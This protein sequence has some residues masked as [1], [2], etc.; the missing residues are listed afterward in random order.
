MSERDQK[1]QNVCYFSGTVTKS[2][3]QE[4]GYELKH[5][6]NGSTVL[7]INLCHVDSWQSNDEQKSRRTFVPLVAWDDKAEKYADMISTGCKVKVKSSYR[8]RSYEKEGTKIY[9][10]DFNVFDLEVLEAEEGGTSQAHYAPHQ[11]AAPA[12]PAAEPAPATPAAD[13]T[14]AEEVVAAGG[15]PPDDIPF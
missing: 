13:T 10:H 14:Q 7:T 2:P 3:S 4:Q 8:T 15:T 11:E 12:A 5:L 6:P 9:R 1:D